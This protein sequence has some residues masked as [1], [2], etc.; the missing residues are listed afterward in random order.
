MQDYED[1]QGRSDIFEGV[2]AE[3]TRSVVSN[4][5][6]LA[7]GFVSGITLRCSAFACVSAAAWLRLTQLFLVAKAV[8]F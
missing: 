4:N 5:R 7:V 6:T 3:T 2:I 1:L 8:A